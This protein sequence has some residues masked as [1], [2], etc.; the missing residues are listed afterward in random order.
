MIRILHVLGGLERGGAETM[1]MNLYRAIDRT[2]VQFDFIIHTTKHQAYYD[3][4]IALGGK[5]YSFPAFNGLNY[6]KMKK[7]WKQFFREHPEYKILHSHVRSYASL[8]LP[9]AKKAGLKTIIHSH[10]TSNGNG[11]SSVV[12]RIMQYPLRWQ[13]EYFF[14][15]SKEAGAWLFGNNVVNS[16]KYH[17]LQNAIDTEQYKFDPEI[18]KEYREKLGLGDKKTFIHVGRFH[19][20]KNH[21]FLLNVFAE[22]HKVDSNT[23]LLLAGDGELRPEIEKQITS[24]NL[25]NDVILLGS[26]SDV[27][28][29]LQAADCFLFPSVW[30]GFG[31][32]AVEAQ[33]AGL[34]CVCSDVIP[35]LV[36]VTEQCAFLPT[37]N[38]QKWAEQALLWAKR[39]DSSMNP[40]QSVVEHGFDIK[41]SSKKLAEF[42]QANWRSA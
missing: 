12:K 4:I 30:E 32:V 41:E 22:I 34:P 16:P 28:N 42:Y 7:L 10:S 2:Q 23:V 33:S 18:R 19:P 14:G 36:K 21:P 31:M 17:I 1:V 15:C 8:Y 9:I 11:L 26:R 38:A 37:D 20:A 3:E 27:P 6:F 35:R 39:T 40:I 29:L 13:A 5:I 25:Q 24:L